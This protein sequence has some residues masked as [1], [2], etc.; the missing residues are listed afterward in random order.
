MS[1]NAIL[2]P[3]F[4]QVGLTLFLMHLTGKKRVESILKGETKIKD[5]ALGQ[6]AW[7][8][9]STQVANSFHNQFQL[10]VLFYLACVLALITAQIDI[11]LLVLAWGF[12]ILRLAHAYIHI[13]SNQVV[14]RF[15]AFAAGFFVLVA[16]WVYLAVMLVMAG[17]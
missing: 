11:V 16:M 4:V 17:S 2:F 7:P 14:K 9:Q 3:V 5:I 15:R 10:P 1:A 8:V 13:T 12:V 6:S